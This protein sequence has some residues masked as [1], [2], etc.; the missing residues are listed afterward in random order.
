[1]RRWELTNRRE[2]KLDR[3]SD[4][5]FG[6][7]FRIK[8]CCLRSQHK[9]QA[10]FQFKQKRQPNNFKTICACTVLS[11]SDLRGLQKK[12]SSHDP[13]PLRTQIVANGLHCTPLHGH[14]AVILQCTVPLYFLN[15][16]HMPFVLHM[17][18]NKPN[19]YFYCLLFHNITPYIFVI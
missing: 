13:L 3:N 12:Y 18:Y 10:S 15:V 7:I 11:V 14:A 6:T 4:T 1:M 19:K 17:A 16:C 2:E 9:F 8:K 5:S